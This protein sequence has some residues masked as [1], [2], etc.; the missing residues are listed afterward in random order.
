M[1]RENSPAPIA[2]PDLAATTRATFRIRDSL[3]TGQA[4]EVNADGGSPIR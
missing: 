3:R 4:M 1:V 2:L